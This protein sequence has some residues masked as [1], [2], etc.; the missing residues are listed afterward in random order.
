[1]TLLDLQIHLDRLLEVRAE[2]R[3]Q[4]DDPPPALAARI[5]KVQMLLRAVEQRRAAVRERR[6]AESSGQSL[7][8]ADV[9]Y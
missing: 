1:M 2:I 4:G 6:D 9:G 3:G 5:R 8:L 7:D